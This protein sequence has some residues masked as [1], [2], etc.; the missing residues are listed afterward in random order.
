MLA[1]RPTKRLEAT[2]TVRLSNLGPATW[3]D[4]KQTRDDD[5]I[6]GGQG[7]LLPRRIG[8]RRPGVP[9]RREERPSTL[10]QDMD[11][12]Q[13]ETARRADVS[14][15]YSLGRVS[16]HEWHDEAEAEVQSLAPSLPSSHASAMPVAH[17]PYH[18]LLDG[19]TMF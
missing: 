2:T 13:S 16:E 3:D 8:G 15:T 4:G 19:L 11:G 6:A 17:S 12:E 9:F 5:S 7:L 18:S 14:R 10:S 1:A